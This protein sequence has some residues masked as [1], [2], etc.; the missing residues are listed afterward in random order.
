MAKSD[1]DQIITEM[2][3]TMSK[4]WQWQFGDFVAGDS[5]APATNVYRLARR[6]EVCVDLAGIDKNAI[7]VRVSPGKLIIRGF[8]TA[9]EP[10]GCKHDS[11]RI[12]CMEID[13]GPF[14][15]TVPLPEQVELQRV[16]SRYDN[17]WLWISLPLREHG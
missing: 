3:T 11:M 6:L 15:R 12:L 2:S 10:Q 13:H 4:L 17:G 1:F 7:D 5:W 16:E 14:A 9:P 8:R